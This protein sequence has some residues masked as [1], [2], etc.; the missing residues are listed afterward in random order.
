MP[1]PVKG[2]NHVADAITRDGMQ[3]PIA[4]NLP[5]FQ[6]RAF[7][8]CRRGESC[9]GG[10]DGRAGTGSHHLPAPAADAHNGTRS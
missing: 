6:F 9:R 10:I 4:G 2:I 3:F 1:S 8:A 5:G 7:L